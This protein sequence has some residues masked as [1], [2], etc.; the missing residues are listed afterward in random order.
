VR[1]KPLRDGLPARGFGE[2][3]LQRGD[4]LRAHDAI[5]VARISATS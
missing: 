3:G 5:R 4:G 2:L 1:E